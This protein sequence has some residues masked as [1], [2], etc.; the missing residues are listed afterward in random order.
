MNKA[1]LVALREYVENL[2]TKT[3]WIGILSFPVLLMIGILVPSYLQKAK[4]V[5]KFAVLD[6]S[7][8]LL[9]ATEAHAAIPDFKKMFLAL[10][11]EDVDL[12]ALAAKGIVS[13]QMLDPLRAG[14]ELFRNATEEQISKAAEQA[15]MQLAP[16]GMIR[17]LLP[18]KAVENL[19]AALKLWVDVYRELNPRDS[20]DLV[21]G[22]SKSRYQHVALE[23][24]GI[25]VDG[26]PE[27]DLKKKI[28]SGALFAYFVIGED[29]IGEPGQPDKED[30]KYVSNNLT[31][32]DLQDWF[33]HH[34]SSVVR[35]KRLEKADVDEQKVRYIEAPL[36]FQEKQVAEGGREEKDVSTQDKAS[37]F[38]PVV[39]VYLLWIS[40]FTVAQMLLTNTVEEKSNRIIEVLLSSVSPLQLMSGKILGIAATGL[41]VVGSWV[42]FFYVTTKVL[43]LFVDI[44]LP[45]DASAI[46]R[47]PVYLAS[48]LL[49]FLFGYLL[50]AAIL[51]ALG[52]VCDSL[53][54]AQ[55][56]MQP[57][58]L[59]LIVPLIA[60][61]P[62]GQD[63][64]GL[65]A[66][67]M[68]YIPVFT[69]FVMMNRAAGPPSTLDYALTTVLLVGFIALTFWG[70][71][72]IFRVG[73]L[74]TG[75]PPK[76]REILR[77]LKAPVG[78]VPERR[79]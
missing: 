60:M 18:E 5:R 24:L 21:S 33:A 42:V 45:F 79:S 56:L 73:V 72:K 63:P 20:K 12:D 44:T 28:S 37:K 34:A 39:F 26:D 66:R 49:Y 25:S 36:R 47:E 35:A 55:N 32:D 68:S 77:W 23:D 51:V 38:A 62:I 69:P 70:A 17:R 71:A 67:V 52:S 57:V 22:L 58:I 76:L 9:E 30:C 41:T 48:F 54:E 43:P 27:S 75:K 10:Q 19:D 16:G 8:W 2:R 78:A 61:V 50:Y 15:A 65:L 53:K 4:D 64:N 31:D 11:K 40:V 14:L 29:P 1:Y 6:R 59:L 3:F 74:M 46:L 7:G 13:Q